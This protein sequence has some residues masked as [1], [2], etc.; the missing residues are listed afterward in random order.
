MCT[1][2]TVDLIEYISIIASKS[3]VLSNDLYV[4][5]F[6]SIIKFII[7]QTLYLCSNNHESF[8]VRSR[9]GSRTSAT[10]RR[11]SVKDR[12]GHRRRQMPWRWRQ[13]TAPPRVCGKLVAVAMDIINIMEVMV[14]VILLINI[15]IDLVNFSTSFFYF[16]L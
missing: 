10:S 1:V 11:S 7:K 2:K 6:R 12:C 3:W 13:V 5:L 9:L 8:L 4:S 16:T 15:S 14:V